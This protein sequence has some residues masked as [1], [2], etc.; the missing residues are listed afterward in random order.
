MRRQ[1]EVE[2]DAKLALYAEMIEGILCPGSDWEDFSYGGVRGKF[3]R[4]G[5]RTRL[6]MEDGGLED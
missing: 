3:A 6:E 5:F 2:G 1:S 4:D